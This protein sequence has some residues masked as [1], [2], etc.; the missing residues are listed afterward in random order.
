MGPNPVVSERR[1]QM[2]K[3]SK[4]N[5]IPSCEAGGKDI[6]LTL[7]EQFQGQ[8]FCHGCGTRFPLDARSEDVGLKMILPKHLIPASVHEYRLKLE[9]EQ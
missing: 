1:M 2:A 6:V 9:R 7:N 5:A 8:V 3:Q 4:K